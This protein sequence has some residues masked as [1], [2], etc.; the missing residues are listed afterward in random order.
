MSEDSNRNT[1]KLESPAGTDGQIDTL[2]ALIPADWQPVEAQESQVLEADLG[3]DLPLLR[4]EES[5]GKWI[6]TIEVAHS[7]ETHQ[8]DVCDSHSAVALHLRERLVHYGRQLES[9]AERIL[10]V[11]DGSG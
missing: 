8:T 5:D 4:I 10:E 1:M 2:R 9:R 11:A 6:G 7:D 3:A